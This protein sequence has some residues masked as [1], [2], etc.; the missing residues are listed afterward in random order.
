MRRLQLVF[1][2]IFVLVISICLAAE[3]V[4]MAQVGPDGIQRIEIVGGSYFFKPNRITL[5]VNVP[6]EI[7]V[8]KE[9]GFVPHDIM[10]NSPEAGMK[11]QEG[12]T[13]EPR[14][15]GFVPTK[16]GKYPFFCSKK[17]MG[18]SHRG[19]GMEGIIEVVP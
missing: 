3:P 2:P 15:I 18:S 6:A 17:F 9:S 16:T 8:S 1:I 19:K 7:K 11:F 12:L 14:I 13:T 4:Q 5:K 10:M